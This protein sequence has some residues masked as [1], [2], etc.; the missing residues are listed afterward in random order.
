MAGEIGVGLLAVGVGLGLRHGIDW[1][2][3]AAIT[4]V[5]STQPSRLRGFVMGTLY[6]L[7]HATVVVLLGLLA[8]WASTLLPEGIDAIMERLVG[9]TLVLLGVWVFWS[10]LRD[11]THFRLRS[12]WM[13]LFWTV[14]RA[15]QWARGKVTGHRALEPVPAAASYGAVASTVIGM[16]HGF[17]AETGSQALILAGAAGATSAFAGSFLLL[18]F[19]IGLV[20]SN[21]FITLG[22][23]LGI[24]GS[25]ARRISYLVVGVLVGAFSLVVGSFFLLGRSSLLPGFFS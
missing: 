21:S 25:Q 17:G 1:D 15:Y 5:T 9:V 24:L 12:R 16:I 14:R 4:D 10:L 18:A 20:I 8:I 2:H 23:T 22:S 6:A 13:L 19:V 3:I 7:G 11:P